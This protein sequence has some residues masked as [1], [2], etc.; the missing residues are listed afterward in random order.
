MRIKLTALLAAI[1][2][3][4]LAGHAA[5][6]K[7]KHDIYVVQDGSGDYKTVTEALDGIRAYMDYVVTVHIADGVYKEKIV[8]PAWLKNVV[9]EGQSAEGTVITFDHHANIDNMGTF[10]SYTVKVDASDII[11]RNL[12]IEN[13]APQLGQAVALHTEGDRLHFINCRLLG[14]QDTL[15]TGGKNTRLMFEDCYIEGT[16]D[17]IFGSATAYFK[18]CTIHSKRNSYVTAAS[19]PEDVKIGYVFDRCKLTAAPDVTK[20]YLGR[21][22]RPYA[23]TMF[24]NCELGSHILPAGWHNWNN[25]ANEATARYG[26]YGSTGPGASADGRVA[27][28]SNPSD[29]EVKALLDIENVFTQTTS[30]QPTDC[31]EKP[32]RFTQPRAK[33]K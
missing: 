2:M 30:W 22:W 33:K 6:D 8:I 24:I 9:F 11:F 23:H 14:N 18:E 3:G 32:Q 21:P 5:D 1:I 29:E 15:F 25:A 17:F 31:Y 10:R 4:C 28:A 7:W 12:T 16:T 13:N 27:W 26:E 20:V 19:T